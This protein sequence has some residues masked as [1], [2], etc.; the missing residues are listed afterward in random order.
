MIGLKA[1]MVS[2]YSIK[3]QLNLISIVG[4]RGDRGLPGL[5]GLPG[6]A[7][8]RGLVSKI[9]IS[10]SNKNELRIFF[11]FSPVYLAP[12]DYQDNQVSLVFQ[13]K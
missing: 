7:G 13:V 9:K 11:L 6:A 10:S 4:I 5:P 2:L 3:K 8:L 12:M 1:L